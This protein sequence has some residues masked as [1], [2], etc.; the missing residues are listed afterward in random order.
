MS[1]DE[2]GLEQ[3]Q[4]RCKPAQ[5]LQSARLKATA[6]QK[7]TDGSGARGYKDKTRLGRGASLSHNLM[8][9][10]IYI[11][12]RT[13][14]YIYVY[15]HVVV[16]FHES[17]C[18]WLS[19]HDSPGATFEVAQPF[20]RETTSSG[21]TTQFNTIRRKFAGWVQKVTQLAGPWVLCHIHIHIIM[22]IMI[23]MNHHETS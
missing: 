10:Y 1:T 7:V 23:I 19:F 11:C 6:A 13:Y 20:I 2:E 8:C 18:K 4:R 14:T 5:D 22:I 15:H 12:I 9:V 21:L 16:L 17:H 3:E